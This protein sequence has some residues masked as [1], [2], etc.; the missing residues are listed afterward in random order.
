MPFIFF[1]LHSA[2]TQVLTILSTGLALGA[3]VAN[4]RTPQD[5]DFISTLSSAS[6]VVSIVAVGVLVARMVVDIRSLV[7][8]LLRIAQRLRRGNPIA[9]REMAAPCLP[10]LDEGSALQR[11]RDA[12]VD[13]PSGLALLDDAVVRD[14]ILE[15]YAVDLDALREDDGDECSVIDDSAFWDLDGNCLQQAEEE[16]EH[17]LV[18]SQIREILIAS[19][20]DDNQNQDQ[21]L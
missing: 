8:A 6:A 4:S 10:S 12:V 15:E 21:P 14:G 1:H 3:A 9:S 11:D 7:V 16:L 19:S 13:E 20:H 18:S 5:L 2:V 17:G